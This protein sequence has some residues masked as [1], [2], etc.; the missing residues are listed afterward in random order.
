MASR[1]RKIHIYHPKPERL[2]TAIEKKLPDREIVA[3]T[4]EEAFLA[5]IEEVEALIAFRPPRG[6]WARAVMLRLLQTTGAGVDAVLPA[7][8]LPS[9]VRVTNARGIHGEY[10]AEFALAMVL[11]F[12]KRIPTWLEEKAK[13]HWKYHSLGMLRDKRVSILGIG[14]IGKEVARVFRA[15]N[16][17]VSGTRRGGEALQ[18]VSLVVTPEKTKEIVCDADFVIVLLPLTPETRGFVNDEILEAMPKKAVLINLA[19]GGIVDENALIKRLERGLLRGAA[20]DVFSQEPLSPNDPIWDAPN[21]IVTP[22]LSG[23]FPGYEDRLANIF[24]YNLLAL[25]VGNSLRNEVNR[26]LGY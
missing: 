19:R 18:N 12:E 23:W 5:G 1:I 25:E 8:D 7:S 24:V 15:M 4:K 10:M 20:M 26:T 17:I 22:H 14:S 3:W 16:M 21:T 9:R 13:H 11:A 6:E 2:I